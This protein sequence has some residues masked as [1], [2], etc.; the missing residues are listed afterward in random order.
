[1]DKER[2]FREKI[3]NKRLYGACSRCIPA[4]PQTP[5]KGENIKTSMKLVSN[6]KELF[7]TG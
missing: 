1:M 4:S 2:S 3:D 5:V 6:N 7:S